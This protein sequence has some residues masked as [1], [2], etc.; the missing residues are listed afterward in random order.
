LQVLPGAGAGP[1]PAG[2]RDPGPGPHRVRGVP[3]AA[4]GA[5]GRCSGDAVR[6]R[7]G[8]RSGAGVSDLDRELPSQPAKYQYGETHRADAGPRLRDGKGPA[9]MSGDPGGGSAM[10][11]TLLAE[12]QGGARILTL[13]RPDVLNAI[14]AQMGD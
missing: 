3:Q 12:T 4:G 1:P 11:E 9:S 6:P 5:G 14:N 8:L 13:N 7:R 2:A 10:Y